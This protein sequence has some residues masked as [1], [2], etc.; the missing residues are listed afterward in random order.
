MPLIYNERDWTNLPRTNA[1][2]IFKEYF[3]LTEEM[4]N[5]YR[6]HGANLGRPVAG[7]RNLRRPRASLLVRGDVDQELPPRSSFVSAK[8]PRPSQLLGVPNPEHCR[9]GLGSRARGRS[10]ESMTRGLFGSKV[11]AAVRTTSAGRRPATS[12]GV[13]GGHAVF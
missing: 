7:G 11:C 3:A 4:R 6:E 12:F 5:A 2:A 13:R 1:S 9:S 8:R 10:R